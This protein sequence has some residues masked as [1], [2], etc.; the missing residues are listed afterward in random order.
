MIQPTHHCLVSTL[1]T[2]KNGHRAIELGPDMAGQ[3]QIFIAGVMQHLQTAQHVM[4]PNQNMDH[5]IILKCPATAPPGGYQMIHEADSTFIEW[6]K[7][8]KVEL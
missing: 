1:S 5:I 8:N 3:P 6:M 4:T 2:E 7:H